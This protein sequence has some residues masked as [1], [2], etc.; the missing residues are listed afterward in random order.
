VLSF[1]ESSGRHAARRPPA[2]RPNHFDAPHPPPSAIPQGRPRRIR[3]EKQVANAPRQPGRQT[4]RQPRWQSPGW[5]SPEGY[6]VA[7][8]QRTGRAAARLRLSCSTAMVADIAAD[9]TRVGSD[10]I[11][12]SPRPPG[13]P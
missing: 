10:F 6:G 13:S 4:G 12:L 9:L 8:P 7:S 5:Q 11:A 3:T 2:R 1:E